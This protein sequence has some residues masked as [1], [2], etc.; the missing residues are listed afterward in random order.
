MD[1]MVG[2]TTVLTLGTVLVLLGGALPSLALTI[3]PNLATLSTPI[4]EPETRG[5]DDCSPVLFASSDPGEHELLADAWIDLFDA[6]GEGRNPSLAEFPADSRSAPGEPSYTSL[7]LISPCGDAPKLPGVDPCALLEL[8]NAAATDSAFSTMFILPSCGDGVSP[9]PVD[10]EGAGYPAAQTYSAPPERDSAFS[11]IVLVEV[12]CI[13]G[14]GPIS[15]PDPCDD[16]PNDN[17]GSF[18]QSFVAL[19][20]AEFFAFTLDLCNI[21]EFPCIASTSLFASE[22][23]DCDPGDDEGPG[24]DGCNHATLTES[25]ST[26]RDCDDSFC[27]SMDDAVLETGSGL[28]LQPTMQAS[29][30]QLTLASPPPATFTTTSFGTDLHDCVPCFILYKGGPSSNPWDDDCDGVD[31]GKDNCP[32]RANPNQKNSD[33]D[34]AGNACDRDDD[35]DG[36]NDEWD[37]CP[38]TPNSD[39]TDRDGDGAGDACDGDDDGD[40]R[41]DGSDSCPH[42]YDSGND[43]DND[44]VG[45]ACDP[46]DD[47]D[48]VYDNSDNCPGVA[49]SSQ[50][51][52][53]NDGVGDACDSNTDSD[54]DGV[55]D[56]SDNCPTIPNSGQQDQDG[57]GE[58]DAC[59]SDTDGDGHHNTTD[60]CPGNHNPSQADSDNDG[61]GDACDGFTDSDGDGVADG[62][63]N[64]DSIYNP[65]QTD[66]DMDG[67]GDA[68]D[69]DADN[70]GVTN[71][72][73]NCPVDPNPSQADADGDGIGDTC[74]GFQDVDHDGVSEPPDNC[75]G[76]YNPYQQNHDGDGQGDDCDSDDDNDGN[77]DTSD[78]CDYNQDPCTTP[79]S[80][81]DS[82]PDSYDN[83][84]YTYN[85]YQQ[86]W[87]Y[88][89]V[90]DH[91]QDYDG[92][93][94]MD[95]VDNYKTD[96][97]QH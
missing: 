5:G 4:S 69:G 7:S 81:S 14:P 23:G 73:D 29:D 50:T 56:S 12:D 54:N 37:N 34:G 25:S 77:P 88:D 8:K 67:E 51:D 91:C 90:G 21:D 44:G 65:G 62:P 39:Q 74:D 59:E 49:N 82:H 17:A 48:G 87:N 70:D 97:S 18:S 20:S 32:N 71:S 24:G 66:A 72:A 60:N 31:D 27:E 78:T 93:G 80:D 79:N 86:D 28:E 22:A 83:C 64:C 19:E 26:D 11:S 6:P 36:V 95:Y 76:V 42:N 84:D 47:G 3:S 9:E 15:P 16:K 43:L 38:T 58:G 53:D 10:C 89:N 35:N 57:D 52:T 61:V 85:P 68:C 75:P 94:Y 55:A 45:D 41:P 46:D 40:G 1:P 13:D 30:S 2:K 33:G 63:D 92:D 96:P